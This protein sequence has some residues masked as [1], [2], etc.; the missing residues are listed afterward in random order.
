MNYDV[1]WSATAENQ[2]AQLWM[3]ESLRPLLARA[4]SAIDA[5]LGRNAHDVGESREGNQRIE[6]ELP[7]AV[8][9]ECDT[10][11][12]RAKVLYIWAS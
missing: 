8:I 4:T 6:F 11:S 3:D 12:R 1:I 10:A 5:R 7:F 2:L 9:F